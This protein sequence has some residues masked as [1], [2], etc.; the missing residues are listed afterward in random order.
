MFTGLQF[1]FHFDVEQLKGDLAKVLPGEWAPHY[2]D[3]DYG[4]I[5]RGVAL[6]S[7]TGS[8][9]HLLAMPGGG[10]NFYDT[11]ALHRCSYFRE[12][13][14]VFR[15][16][17]KSVR[18]LG[19]A[20]GSYIR[21][22]S[23]QALDYEDGEIRIHVPILTNPGVEFYLAGERLQLDEGCCYYVNVNLPHR[24]N[25]RGS[26]ER[27]HLV[28]DAEVNGWVHQLFHQGRAEG[29]HIPRSPLPPGSLDD[30]RRL[31]LRDENLQERLRGI[32][33]RSEFIETVIRMGRELGF[34][35]H[36]G[37]VSAGFRTPV[38]A[39]PPGTG[40]TPTCVL[41]AEQ[42]P[43]V[44][45]LWTGET[46]FTEPFFEDTIRRCARPPFAALFRRSAPLELNPDLSAP[47]GFIFHMSRCGSTLVSQMLASSSR[48]A[49]ISEAPPIDEVVRTENVEWLRWIVS[50]LSRCRAPGQEH[51]FVKLDAWHIHSLP[52]IRQAFPDTPWIFL[53]RD[54]LEV[55]VSQLRSPGMFM[56]CEDPSLGREGWCVHVFEGILRAAGAAAGDP[57]GLFVNYRHLPEAVLGEICTHFGI[58]FTAEEREQALEAAKIDAKCPGLSFQGD[59]QEKRAEASPR[60]RELVAERLSPLYGALEA[61]AI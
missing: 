42:E 57:M 50:A 18:L 55:A 53:Y 36:G 15:C 11:A 54:P 30:F 31:V 27:I 9:T 14:S 5:W 61:L 21:E 49:M 59:S 17:L 46:R 8:S 40:W 13:L 52:L 24:V 19:L 26:A 34:D 48:V 45:W 41:V 25:N 10:S 58:A 20:P 12:V 39:N 33:N 28:I 43:I 32:E 7:A 38:Q 37:D 1:P 29:R 44:H 16:P 60:L 51:C 56:L 4:G 23:D 3:R 2:N 47:S 35:F 6:R 22:H